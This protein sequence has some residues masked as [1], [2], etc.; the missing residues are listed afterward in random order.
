MDPLLTLL[1]Q[2]ATTFGTAALKKVADSA[3]GDAWAAVKSALAR[4][5]PDAPEASKLVEDLRVTPAGPQA[6]GIVKRLEE[7]DVT[8]DAEIADAIRNLIATLQAARPNTTLNAPIANTVYGP[9]VAYGS[10]TYNVGKGE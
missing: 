10:M 9:Q 6:E 5:R 2:A 1:L 4:K 3:V 8:R 7:F